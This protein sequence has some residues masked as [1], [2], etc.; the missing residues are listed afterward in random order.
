M[1]G[2]FLQRADMTR[3]WR[4]F[5]VGCARPGAGM[6]VDVTDLYESSKCSTMSTNDRRK[7]WISLIELQTGMMIMMVVEDDCQEVVEERE[8]WR[9]NSKRSTTSR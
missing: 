9:L 4:D 1:C 5:W 8:F 6:V 2:L 7:V 3:R